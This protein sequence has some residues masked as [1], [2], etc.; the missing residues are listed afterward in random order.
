MC[1]RLLTAFL[2][3][4]TVPLLAN[5][6]PL[7]DRVPKD[8]VVYI[9]WRGSTA[10]GEGYDQSH[11]KALLE[12]SGLPRF[13]EESLPVALQRL[14]QEEPDA[15]EAVRVFSE[16]GRA[17]WKYPTAL[18]TSGL[19][20]RDGV[21][22]P[23]VGFLCQ[24]GPD[25]ATLQARLD[26]LLLQMPKDVPVEV[27]TFRTDG[28]LVGVVVG[29]E[30]AEFKAGQEGALQSVPAF[31]SAM[32][33]LQPEP[34]LAVYLDTDTLRR[35]GE[36]LVTQFGDPDV[37][38]EWPRIRDALGLEGLKQVAF[39]AGF[40][41]KRWET[42]VFVA[43]PAPRKGL[44]KLLEAE[45]VTD[46]T[47]KLI[48]RTAQIAGAVN[49]DPA[50]ILAEARNVAGQLDPE[51]R[52]DIDRGLQ[53]VSQVLGVDIENDLIASVGKEW[54]FYTA[55]TVGGNGILGVVLVNRPADAAKAQQAMDKL[56]DAINRLVAQ[57]TAGDDITIRIREA[58]APDGLKIKYLATP[59]VSPAWAVRDGNLYVALYPQVVAAAARQ[60]KE[61]QSILENPEFAA[62]RKALAG[63]KG[64]RA[65]S[66]LFLDLPQAVPDAY[67]ALLAASRLA[68]FADIVGVPAPA[69]LL[70][71]IEVLTRHTTPAA[72]ATWTDD[73]GWHFRGTSPFPGAELLAVEMVP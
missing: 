29:Y 59:V 43:A 15:A 72:A 65:S 24:A 23:R 12:S 16:I 61:S 63:E 49:I 18:F 25:A 10:M 66:I 42:N 52:Q 44:L 64:T 46:D 67:P 55:P 73:A 69:M 51:A 6:Q 54:A 11:L 53:E 37:K 62:M 31:K 38:A 41:D 8:A 50:R 68:G 3:A 45:P 34:V 27:R 1:R 19:G 21:P 70:P 40:R 13:V 48:P 35:T 4:A 9:G 39:T 26:D 28:G 30:E 20:V 2:L 14:A 36:R 71:P 17:V 56:A 32:A 60:A 7:A 47:L 5:A 22:T 58:Q 57:E 33:Q